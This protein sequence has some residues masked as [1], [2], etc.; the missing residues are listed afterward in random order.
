ML[1]RLKIKVKGVKACFFNIL[2]V[3][4]Q[5]FLKNYTKLMKEIAISAVI[6]K[7]SEVTSFQAGI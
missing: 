4:L 1:K 2:A 3:I 6:K 7:S 5:Q